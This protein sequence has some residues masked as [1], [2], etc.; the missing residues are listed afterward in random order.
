MALFPFRGIPIQRGKLDL[1][2][3]RTARH[4][5]ANSHLPMAVAPEGATNGHNQIVSPLEPGITQLGF[6]CVEDL[7]KAGRSE[8]VLLVPIG[9]QY[10]YEN[11]LGKL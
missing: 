10:R 3:L 2:G 4:L 6:W 11:P 9:I 5:L 8:Q 1:V 7:L